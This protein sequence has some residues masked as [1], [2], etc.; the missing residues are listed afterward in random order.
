MKIQAPEAVR[1]L[2]S[3]H[4][5]RNK[6]KRNDKGH[7]ERWSAGN[8]Y[9]NNWAAPSY[10]VSVEDHNLHG[11]GAD[12]KQQIWDAAK[13]TIEQWTGM[14]IKPTSMY[15][16]RVYTEGTSSPQNYFHTNLLDSPSLT[17][18]SL[19]R[20]YPCPSRRQVASC[21]L[22]YCQRCA[23]PGRA[24]AIGSHRPRRES[25]QCHYGT[26]RHGSL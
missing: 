10:M 4:W 26:W 17:I 15:G 3:E 14:E 8:I 16:I 21:E 13:D 6:H 19:F 25:S 12:L 5:E 7:E 9:T 11:A 18:L 22:L 23:G 20:S 24:L 2:L 1:K